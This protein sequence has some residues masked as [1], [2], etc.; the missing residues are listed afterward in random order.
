MDYCEE[1]HEYS[2]GGVVIP[3]VTQILYGSS[4]KPW[5]SKASSDRG[6]LAH[7]LCAA[8]ARDPSDAYLEEPYVDAFVLWCS[9]RNPNWKAIEEMIEGKVDGYRYAGRF[10]GLAIIDGLLTLIDWKTGV[11]SK[12]FRAQLGAYSLVAKPA[13]AMVLYLHND[14][15]YDEQLLDPG[16]LVAG[17]QEFRTAIWTYY[18]NSN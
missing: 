18:V 14:G 1:R 12:T 4:P 17:I 7:E 3:S 2:E 5:F 15:T 11:K 8:Y 16:E 9:L 6:H 10:D 13:R